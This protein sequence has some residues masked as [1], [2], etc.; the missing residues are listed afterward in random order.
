MKKVSLK[1]KILYWFDNRISGGSMGL[2]RLLAILSLIVVLLVA[3][4]IFLF[5]LN[6]EDGF[7]AAFWDSA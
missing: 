4:I 5:G 2:I 1:K 7:L 3:L 6:G